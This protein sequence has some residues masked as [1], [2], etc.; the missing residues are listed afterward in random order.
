MFVWKR[1][2]RP[3]FESRQKANGVWAFVTPPILSKVHRRSNGDSL[4]SLYGC[5]ASFFE[6]RWRR[7][8]SP[9]EAMPKGHR[10]NRGSVLLGAA[11]SAS[12]LIA[13]QTSVLAAPSVARSLA[14]AV[15]G[16]RLI[17]SA[18]PTDAVQF[19]IH[20]P[21]RNADQLDDLIASQTTKGSPFY[22]HWLTSAQFRASFGPSAAS[23]AAIETT[24]A[25]NGLAVRRTGTQVLAVRGASADVERLFQTR[26]SRFADAR[27]GRVRIAAATT[28]KAPDV[29]ANAGG[30][31]INL[32]SFL[33]LHPN[34][35]SLGAVGNIPRNR[36]AAY[37][38]YWADD[39]KQ[40]Y[41]FPSYQSVNG[42]GVN[43]AIVGAGDSSDT[44]LALYL[45]HEKFG[46]AVGD[47]APAP[48]VTHRLLPGA[49]GFDPNSGGSF[50]ANLDVQQ[51]AMTAPG[52]NISIF[53][54]PDASDGSFSDAYT[55]IVESN[56]YDVVSTSY[57]GCELQ[58]TPAYNNGLDFTGVVKSEND[59]FKQGNA[60]GITF[61][62]SSGDNGGLG[63]PELGYFTNPPTT[64][65]TVYKS[66][67]SVETPASFPNAVAVGGGELGTTFKKGKLTSLYVAEDGYSDPLPNSDPYG[68]GNLVSSV[69]GAGGGPSVIFKKPAYQRLVDTG[70][71]MR[72]VPDVGGHIGRY[73]ASGSFDAEYL[74]GSVVG[75]LGTSASAPDF[76]GLLALKV[77]S[78]HSRL[79]LENRD[80]YELSKNNHAFNYYFF[81]QS[82]PGN[83]GVY[84]Y[85]RSHQGYNY[86]Y[87]VG[88]P[89]GANF[90]FL[91]FGPFAGDPQTS[92]NP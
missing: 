17:G 59:L 83:D 9:P 92:T 22:H 64:P 88:S 52:A 79:G 66:I 85:T 48:T 73:N 19:T 37:S 68:T 16:H 65:A 40:A 45:A 31:V 89:H 61:V 50:E 63:C 1:G 81:H 62:F 55:Q 74:G 82:N 67:P 91:P 2:V 26:L 54:T 53:V 58:Y 35:R 72:A 69:F 14:D 18:A 84:A 33:P 20:L 38:E 34:Y 23:V 42:K 86:I 46:T 80:I 49:T 57:G 51:L 25:T 4:T 13:A 3:A 32:H 28:M 12:L 76:A 41:V 75:V 29:I 11:L 47:L 10:V 36:Y 21:L 90:A 44:D 70:T 71:G 56:A 39:L 8:R 43:V 6:R 78:Q 24:L 15:P 27:T 5:A 77:Q 30:T 7:S 60:L 87:G